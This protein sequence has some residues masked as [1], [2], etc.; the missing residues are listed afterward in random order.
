MR[1]GTFEGRNG[2]VAVACIQKR[3]AYDVVNVLGFRDCHCRHRFH[4]NRPLRWIVWLGFRS[5]AQRVTLNQSV[6]DGVAYKRII[7]RKTLDLMS[8]GFCT[9][10]FFV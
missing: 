10:I 8:D 1:T 2:A 7:G 5:A 3:C 9:V 4:S 6:L